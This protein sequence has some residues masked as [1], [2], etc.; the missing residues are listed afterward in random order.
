MTT[1]PTMTTTTATEEAITIPQPKKKAATRRR[2]AA[3]QKTDVQVDRQKSS[4]NGDEPETQNGDEK[5]APEYQPSH[6]TLE[7]AGLDQVAAEE[8]RQSELAEQRDEH[9]RRTGD[10]SR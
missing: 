6:P 4:P 1:T 10:A 9:N 8:A 2:P 3:K 5:S 7:N